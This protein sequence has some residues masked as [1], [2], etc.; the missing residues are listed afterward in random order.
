MKAAERRTRVTR[1]GSDVVRQQ[2]T[3]FYSY[4]GHWMKKIEVYIQIQSSESRLVGRGSIRKNEGDKTRLRCS[5]TA[6]HIILQLYRA[7][8]EENRGLYSNAEL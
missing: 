4:T 8:A 7:M 2:I 5:S 3:L 1:Q 6:Y